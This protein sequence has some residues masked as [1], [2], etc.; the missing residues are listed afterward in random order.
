MKIGGWH[1]AGNN[2]RILEKDVVE[3]RSNRVYRGGERGL[4]SIVPSVQ[5]V[6]KYRVRRT[7]LWLS[8]CT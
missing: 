2:G 7:C 1:D 4:P 6:I 5:R 8:V 3:A